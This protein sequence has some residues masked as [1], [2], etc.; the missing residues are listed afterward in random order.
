MNVL[1]L[2]WRDIKNPS[3]GGA[4]NLAFEIA[5]RLQ[6]KGTKVT[7]FTSKFEKSMPKENIKGIKIVR[8]GSLISC[9]LHAFFYYRKHKQKFDLVID[10]INTLPFLTPLFA[11]EKTITLIHQLAK[12]YWFM[13]TTF[14]INF[15]GYFLEPLYLKLY[16]NTPTITVSNSS[17][18]D[19]RQLGFKKI[20]IIREG[21]CLKPTLVKSKKDQ[22]IYLGRLVKAK[23]PK[24]AILAFKEIQKQFKNYQLIIAGT[25]T[26]AYVR[27]LKYLVQKHKLKNV[28]FPGFVDEKTK[29]KLLRDSKI[30]LIPSIREGW[31]L[32][33]L[34][35]QSQSCIPVAYNVPGLSDAIKNN[36]TGI[37]TETKPESMAQQTIRILKNPKLQKELSKNAYKESLNFSWDNTF[38]DFQKALAGKLSKGAH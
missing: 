18:N 5:T 4:E 19:L 2:S 15:L 17:A 32:V 1:W 9:R 14:P 21:L 20:N 33:A 22:I 7:I 11:R 25:G 13:H 31:G 26:R 27:S 34:E 36:K 38:S 35:A 23:G 37:L 29:L 12:E 16:R 28:K 30:I 24:K 6:K 8:V 3:A 10:E